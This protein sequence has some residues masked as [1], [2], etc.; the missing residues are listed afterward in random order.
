MVGECPHLP[1]NPD[2]CD[3]FLRFSSKIS[4]RLTSP[5]EP[6]IG[7]VHKIAKKYFGSR[8]HFWH[9][10]DET[11]DE[12]QYGYHD[13]QTVHDASKKLRE[14]WDLTDHTEERRE[15]NSTSLSVTATGLGRA[16][17][18][19]QSPDLVQDCSSS[20]FALHKHFSSSSPLRTD[21][22]GNV[23]SIR[24]VPG[25]GQCLIATSTIHKGTRILSEAPLFKVPRDEPD[26][27]AVNGHIIRALKERERCI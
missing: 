19:P 23:Y 20:R 14:V 4:G 1:S 17:N 21:A 10:M 18:P 26:L 8:V 3:Y 16:A 24:P 12:R 2:R 25:R 7:G 27:Q 5:A 13:W 6:Y 15:T 11:G 22:T 9:E